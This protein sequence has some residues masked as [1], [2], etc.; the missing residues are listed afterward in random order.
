[1]EEFRIARFNNTPVRGTIY[2]EQSLVDAHGRAPERAAARQLSWTYEE[3]GQTDHVI[4]FD[5][6]PVPDVAVPGGS[7]CDPQNPGNQALDDWVRYQQ[8]GKAERVEPD[9]NLL[10]LNQPHGGCSYPGTKSGVAP[11][12]A[13]TH[14]PGR[15]VA[16]GNDAW[17][18]NVSATMHEAGRMHGVGTSR[19]FDIHPGRGWNDDLFQRWHR[20]PNQNQPG[21]ENACGEPIPERKYDQAVSELWFNPCFYEHWK[22]VDKPPLEQDPGLDPTPGGGFL[23]PTGTLG[24]VAAATGLGMGLVVTADGALNDTFEF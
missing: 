16:R 5:L 9:F 1:M 8:G 2:S 19:I 15:V 7:G 14:D 11:A 10:L 13:I 18:R 23:P 22:V 4:A 17:A 24:A 3:H 6:A 21:I 12:A 20:T